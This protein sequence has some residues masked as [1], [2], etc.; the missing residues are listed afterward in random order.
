MPGGSPP[1]AEYKLKGDKVKKYLLVCLALVALLAT[2]GV[3]YSM[4]SQTVTINGSVTT[5]SVTMQVSN[6]TGTWAWKDVDANSEPSSHETA[7]VFYPYSPNTTGLYSVSSSS[8]PTAQNNGL[9]F[10]QSPGWKGAEAKPIDATELEAGVVAFTGVNPDYTNTAGYDHQ[11]VGLAEVTAVNGNTP[12]GAVSC[13]GTGLTITVA[14][15]NLFPVK[16]PNGTDFNNWC[17]DFD[18][19]NTGTVPVKIEVLTPTAG[20]IT[21]I[22]TFTGAA[23]AITLEGYQLEPGQTVHAMICIPVDESTV[24]G[25]TGTFNITLDAVQWNEY[26][27]SH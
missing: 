26:S 14:Y 23:G 1:G 7:G 6:Y 2:M 24:Q 25:A 12:T 17:A 16:A 9:L 3:G 15:D 8:D 18:L 20:T 21:P 22:V 4:W 5:G 13:T 11:M 10:F 19:S 27:A